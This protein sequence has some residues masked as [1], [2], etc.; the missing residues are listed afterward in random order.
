MFTLHILLPFIART[1]SSLGL[2]NTHSKNSCQHTALIRL[3]HT[4]ENHIPPWAYEEAG[5][6][7]SCNWMRCSRR[8]ACVGR[9]RN[10][11]VMGTKWKNNCEYMSVSTESSSSAIAPLYDRSYFLWLWKQTTLFLKFYMSSYKMVSTCSLM[12]RG[13]ATNALNRSISNL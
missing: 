4:R 13:Q 8:K 3:F 7:G 5:F 1:M 11:Y 2:L 6:T 10:L 9:A 12:T